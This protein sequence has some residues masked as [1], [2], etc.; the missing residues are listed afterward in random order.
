MTPAGFETAIPAGE[1]PLIH[2]SDRKATAN[3]SSYV[4]NVK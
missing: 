3:G 2:A 1:R 4:E